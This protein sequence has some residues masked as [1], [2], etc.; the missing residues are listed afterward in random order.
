MV[1][2]TAPIFTDIPN[3]GFAP[4][5]TAANTAKDGTGTVDLVFTA[6]ADGAFLQKLKIRPKGTNVATVLRVFLNNGA[7]PTTATNNML[8]DEIGLP[9]TTN[10][11]TTAI[12]GLELAMNLALPAGWRVYV[13]LG[14]AVAGGYSVTA[15]GGNY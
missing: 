11:E 7:T 14:T 8:Y 3:I 4:A 10:I 13:T 12:V 5:I 1:A 15:V 6:G 2:N 9:A